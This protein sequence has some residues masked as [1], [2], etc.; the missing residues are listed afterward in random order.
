MRQQLQ[1]PLRPEVPAVGTEDPA[2]VQTEALAVVVLARGRAVHRAE[3][4]RALGA[5][6]WADRALSTRTGS[7]CR[8]GTLQRD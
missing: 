2:A 1:R 5:V 6:K 3:E 8:D 7:N 4:V